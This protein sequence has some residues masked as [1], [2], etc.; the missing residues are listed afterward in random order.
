MPFWLIWRS[1]IFL[2]SFFYLDISHWSLYSMLISN[3]KHSTSFPLTL[4]LY[5]PS[6]L[7][8]LVM[9]GG[10]W[11]DSKVK[12]RWEDGTDSEPIYCFFVNLSFTLSTL[13]LTYSLPSSPPLSRT[14]AFYGCFC[15]FSM[16]LLSPHCNFI[17]SASLTFRY[18]WN[19]RLWHF[20]CCKR[21]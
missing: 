10:E 12:S 1:M 11:P 15:L 2:I 19:F 14:H 7:Y 9:F 13:C 8:S 20:V 3:V 6:F 17:A 5:S 16:F 21:V 4:F 18:F